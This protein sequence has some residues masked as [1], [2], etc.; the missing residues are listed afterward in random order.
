MVFLE[1][2]RFQQS[3]QSKLEIQSN[4]VITASLIF[5]KASINGLKFN[6]IMI[7][8]DYH[9][10]A[11]TLRTCCPFCLFE[12]LHWADVVD[13]VVVRQLPDS[14]LPHFCNLFVPGDGSGL[15][16]SGFADN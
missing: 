7:D 14:L 5:M 11:N 10:Q 15:K 13:L 4:V 9:A 8:A 16:Y 3:N 6:C 1:C 12:N 2:L